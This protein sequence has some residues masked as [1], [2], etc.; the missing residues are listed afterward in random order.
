MQLQMNTSYST[1]GLILPLTCHGIFKAE[2]SALLPDYK[3]AV[4]RTL[5]T[6]AQVLV[7]GRQASGT[8]ITVEGSVRFT[9]CYQGEDGEISYVA[10][11][12]SYRES[13]ECEAPQNALIIVRGYAADVTARPASA[14]KIDFSASVV[15]KICAIGQTNTQI[16]IAITADN[17]EQKSCEAA[18]CGYTSSLER[19][20]AVSDDLAL[21]DGAPGIAQLLSV[22][23]EAAEG[24]YKAVNGKLIFKSELKV[25]AEYVSELDGS[26]AAKAEFTI[27]ISRVFDIEHSS[28]P[29]L[30]CVVSVASYTAEAK[31]ESDGVAREISFDAVITLQTLIMEQ[32]QLRWLCDCYSKTHESYVKHNCLSVCVGLST[33][34]VSAFGSAE[35]ENGAAEDGT[36]I[37]LHTQIEDAG[38]SGGELFF[39][40]CVTALYSDAES[41]IS[42]R[43][44]KLR[45]TEPLEQTDNC[46]AVDVY[47]QEIAVKVAGAN[48]GVQVSVKAGVLS[49]ENAEIT[50]LGELVCDD[51]KPVSRASEPLILCYGRAGESVWEL[52]KHYKTCAD[53]IKALNGNIGDILDEPTLLVIPTV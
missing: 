19:Q 48:E 10:Q 20:F 22:S 44:A 15:L 42:T 4:M 27:P 25:S 7:S 6:R 13:V 21:A 1:A 14:R 8:K 23:V 5:S 34:E 36:L 33:E 40:V 45:I 37:A 29:R 26:A 46:K 17:I 47:I 11:N 52:A 2:T 28:D 32:S 49:C 31:S 18:V 3:P 39:A 50:L 38:I 35:Y 12:M 30:I 9:C 41:G 24:E 51:G 53:S 43:R 16:P